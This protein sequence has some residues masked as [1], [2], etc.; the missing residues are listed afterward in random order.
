MSIRM[1]LQLQPGN[2]LVE[3][4]RTFPGP[5]CKDVTIQMLELL[6]AKNIHS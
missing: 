5:F 4:A 6:E 2:L 1:V 3:D